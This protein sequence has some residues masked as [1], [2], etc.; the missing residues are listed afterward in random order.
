[1]KGF[2]QPI[3]R[4]EYSQITKQLLEKCFLGLYGPERTIR[5]LLLINAGAPNENKVQ[6]HLN[7]A[8]LN[9]F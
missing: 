2:L 6:N 9:V 4:Y 8:L 7:I 3:L 5:Q 1:M